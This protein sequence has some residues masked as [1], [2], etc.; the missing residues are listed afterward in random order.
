M[1]LSSLQLL[2]EDFNVAAL[3]PVRTDNPEVKSRESGAGHKGDTAE[4]KVGQFVSGS[5]FWSATQKVN[6]VVNLIEAA[7]WRCGVYFH[8]LTCCYYFYITCSGLL[9]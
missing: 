3:H 5:L 2:L 7:E 1:S 6:K 8:G 9:I 4:V